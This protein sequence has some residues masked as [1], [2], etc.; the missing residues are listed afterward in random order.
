M[1]SV[2]YRLDSPDYQPNKLSCALARWPYSHTQGGHPD[3]T[4]N[5]GDG[6]IVYVEVSASTKI[7]GDDTFKVPT[8]Q[9][10]ETHENR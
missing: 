1:P 2:M 5:Y 4:V 6:L 7:Y 8:G 10:S 9:R 3:V